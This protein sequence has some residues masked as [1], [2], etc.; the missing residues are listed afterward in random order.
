MTTPKSF[1]LIKPSSRSYNPGTYPSTT[2]ESLDGTK[3]HIRYGNKRVNATLQL[4]FSNISDQQAAEI[5]DHYEEVNSDWDY[6]TFGNNDALSGVGFVQGSQYTQFLRNYMKEGDNKTKRAK[7]GSSAEPSGL[8][9]R[10][11][12]PPTVTSIFKG[13]S[14]VSCSFIACLD[15]PVP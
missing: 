3:T 8:R 1:P 12:S 6:V 11:S 9:W 7:D 2:F 10:Y 15:A 14:N 5:L 13:R 4:G